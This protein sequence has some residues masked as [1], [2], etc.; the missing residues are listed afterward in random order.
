MKN[1]TWD[2]FSLPHAKK[3]LPCK[4]V[5]K[6]KVTGDHMP[7]F[8]ARLFAKGSKQ[9]KG[10]YFDEIFSLIVKMTTLRCIFGL[11]EAEDIELV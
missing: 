5:Y 4:W 11:M 6:M 8:K 1:K 9:E 10:V 3:A 7:K 2:L